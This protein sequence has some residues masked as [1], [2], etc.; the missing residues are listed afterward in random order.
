MVLRISATCCAPL[1]PGL[2]AQEVKIRDD[3]VAAFSDWALRNGWEILIAPA[4]VGDS[5][6]PIAETDVAVRKEFG[7]GLDE[8]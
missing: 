6:V 1:V 3:E 2:C 5:G 4:V 7:M 8:T